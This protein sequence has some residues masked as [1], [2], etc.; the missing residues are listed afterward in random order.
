MENELYG[1]SPITE[2]PPTPLP[3]GKRLAFYVGLNI[4]HF[5]FGVPSTSNAPLTAG[6]V[7]DP[8]NHGWRDYGTRVGIW[9]MIDLF[10]ELGL[11]ASAIT[12]SQVC[13]Q[14]PQII[15]AGV[16]RDWAWVAH[17]QTNSALHTGMDTGAEVA[18]LDEML[19]SFDAAL[20]KRPQGW[21]G[22]ALT[23]TAATPRLLRERGFTYLLDWCCDDRPF[24]LRQPGM[25]S[26]P[27][28]LDVNDFS[29]F[30]GKATTGSAYEE[31]VLDQ[32]ET[33]L[34]EGG[35]VMALPLHPFITGQPFRFKYL[36]RVLRAITANPEVWVTTSTDIAERYLAENPGT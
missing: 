9:R 11:R 20:P 5:L 17:G 32:F 27:Y 26:V 28:S 34:A 12:N 7:P 22:P 24:P 36:A 19:R 3:E 21:L 23:E 16:E 15:K 29:V 10:D 13:D 31:M 18:F 4:E 14:Y 2:R 35:A 6:F 33:L 8:L 25:I 30:I 1:Y